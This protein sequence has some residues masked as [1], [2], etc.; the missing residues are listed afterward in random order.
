M[1]SKMLDTSVLVRYAGPASIGRQHAWEAVARLKKEAT[2]GAVC[3]HVLIEFWAVATRPLDKNGLAMTFVE[4]KEWVN[5]FTDELFQVIDDTPKTYEKWLELVFDYSVSGFHTYD[6]KV[7]A[8]AIA[9]MCDGV[10][11]FDGDFKKYESELP[12]EFLNNK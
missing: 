1:N 6:A 12:I 7:V 3:P 10:I 8:S 5:R 9:G 2:Q 11:A 4:A